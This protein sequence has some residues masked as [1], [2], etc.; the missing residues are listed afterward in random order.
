MCIRDS[1]RG[2]KIAERAPTIIFNFPS[3]IFLHIHPLDDVDNLECQ[4]STTS[5][6]T[7]LNR[8]AI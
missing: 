5:P 8:L 7:D 6:K 1:L 3:Q 4:V 2:V